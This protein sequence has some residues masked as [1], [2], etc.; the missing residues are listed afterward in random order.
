MNQISDEKVQE[1]KQQLEAERA[2]LINRSEVARHDIKDSPQH[3]G[4]DSVDESTAEQGVSTMLEVADRHKERMHEINTALDR[5]EEGDYGI[6]MECEELIPEKRLE[7]QPTSVLCISCKEKREKQQR[8][9]K[10]RP[11]LMD[12]MPY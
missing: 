8:D 12:D 3:R 1:F 6:C 9:D 4:G 2:D 7:A 5:I 11:G 10:L